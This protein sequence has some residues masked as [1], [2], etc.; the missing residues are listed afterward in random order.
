MYFSVLRDGHIVKQVNV[1]MKTA[2]EMRMALIEKAGENDEFRA[3][4]LSDPK[5]AIESEFGVSVPEGFTLN[6]HED[7]PAS[8]HIVLPPDPSL[9]TAQLMAAAG[10]GG[11]GGGV[12][13][14]A[15]D[16][17]PNDGY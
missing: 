14:N 6:V 13:T 17:D 10:G 4:L 16:A 15:P 2:S 12:P 9:T 8:A 3:R 1:N 7:S 11:G 5:A